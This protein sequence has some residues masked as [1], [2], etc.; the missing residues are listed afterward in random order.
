MVERC[1]REEYETNEKCRYMGDGHGDDYGE[2]DGGGTT[3]SGSAEKGDMVPTS[4]GQDYAHNLGDDLGVG[5]AAG[6][7]GR[8]GVAVMSLVVAAVAV[9][10]FFV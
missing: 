8:S 2:R 1:D 7:D 3:G 9:M 5:A 6:R 10:R 4:P